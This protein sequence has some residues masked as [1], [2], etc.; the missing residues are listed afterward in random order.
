MLDGGLPLDRE[1]YVNL[2][3]AGGLP[4]EWTAEHEVELPRPFQAR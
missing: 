4:D 2:A 3:Y 1:T